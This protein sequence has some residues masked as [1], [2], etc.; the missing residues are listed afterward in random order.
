MAT[1]TAFAYNTGSQISGTDQVGSLAVGI[2]TSGFGSTG[3]NH[4]SG[5][6]QD[7][8]YVIAYSVPGNNHPAPDV[9]RKIE[10]SS[11]YRGTDVQLSNGAQTAHQLFGYQQSVLGA[12][13][14]GSDDKVMFSI[15]VSLAAPGT[16]TNSHFIGIGKTGMYYQGNPY[17]GYP[18]NDN[19]STGYS[20]NPAKLYYNGNFYASNFTNWGDGDLVDVCLYNNQIWVRVNGGWWNNIEASNPA[21]PS[22]GITTVITAPYYPVLCPGYEGTMTIQ[23]ISK[24]AIPQGYSLLGKG[25]ASVG[26]VRSLAKT[27]ESFI[28]KAEEVSQ[29]TETFATGIEAKTWLNSNGYWTSWASFGSS[30]F[31][32]MTINSVTSTTASGI[33]QNS[34]TI[35]VTQTGG[36]MGITTGVFNPTAFPEQYGVPFTGNQIQNTNSGVFTATF[37][38]PV[39]NPLVAFASVGQPGLQ[40][41]VISTLPFTPIFSQATT[42]QNPVN[43]TQ[44]TQFIGEE[45]YNIIRID[46]TVSQISFTYTVAEFYCNVCFGFVDQNA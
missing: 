46:G 2:P 4:W 31:Q 26:F 24:F 32:W 42:Y 39:L 43:G 3:L 29:N 5:P 30:G 34:I 23:N 9:S 36:G 22:G 7:L 15:L 17:G 10:L 33:G 20:S 40:V 27:E 28:S 18:G 14:I 19:L 8:G 16:Q 1:A 21:T 13:A 38:Q 44:Y 45:G 11:T 41:P 25:N 12:S 37:S 6:D 35:A